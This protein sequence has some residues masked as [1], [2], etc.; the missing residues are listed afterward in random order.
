MDHVSFTM[1]VDPQHLERY[2]RMHREAWPE[3]LV[4]LSETGYRNYGLFLRAD[5]FLVGY[6]ESD[7]WPGTRA[8]MD[9]DAVSARWSA[10]MD[11]LVVPGTR[12]RWLRTLSAPDG[13]ALDGSAHR[14]LAVGTRA[15]DAP[16]VGRTALFVD[17]ELGTLVAYAEHPDDAR[18]L[19]AAMLTDPDPVP[20]RRVFDLERQLALIPGRRG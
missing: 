5:G 6:F 11:Q 1:R 17:D 8:A 18:P 4:A 13:A 3:L 19:A 12:M 15:A 10:E 14:T 20:F 9:A 2:E 7:D 16:P